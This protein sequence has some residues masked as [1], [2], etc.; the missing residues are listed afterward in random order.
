MISTRPVPLN[1]YPSIR[2]NFDPD[3]KVIEESDPHP[4]KQ[5]TPMTSTDDG[6]MIA[7]KTV[8]LNVYPSI[9]DN[10]DPVSNVTEESDLHS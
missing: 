6:R 2:D 5:Y 3:S 8:P 10:I 7:T 4:A 1:A 9:R